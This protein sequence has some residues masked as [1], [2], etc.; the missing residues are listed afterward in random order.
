VTSNLAPEQAV[1]DARL[2]LTAPAGTSYQWKKDGVN[3]TD[4][5]PRVTGTTSQTLIID[6]LEPSDSGAY[7]VEYEAT[8]K[9][10]GLLETDPFYLAVDLF[11]LLEILSPPAV[12]AAAP[13]ALMV[14][15][16]LLSL[17][18]AWSAARRARRRATQGDGQLNQETYLAKKKWLSS[19]GDRPFKLSSG[20]ACGYGRCARS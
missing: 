11:D 3:L 18:G 13:P 17:T 19:G 4:S 15:G 1:S 5:P 10:A 12:P 20:R 6:P 14:L 7:T 2:V 9:R 8:G 16:V